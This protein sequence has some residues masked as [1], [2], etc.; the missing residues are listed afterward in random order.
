MVADAKTLELLQLLGKAWIVTLTSSHE[1]DAWQLRIDSPPHWD[2][3]F[4]YTYR[5]PLARVV[6]R[7]YAGELDDS[8]AEATLCAH[9]TTFP[10]TSKKAT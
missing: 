4:S 8:P 3:R 6:S 5:G 9:H 2:E 7:A 10:N 1:D